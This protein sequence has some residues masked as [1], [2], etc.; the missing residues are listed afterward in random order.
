LPD[1][2]APHR[3]RAAKRAAETIRQGLAPLLARPQIGRK[4]EKAPSDLRRWMIGFSGSGYVI[5][6]QIKPNAIMI[7]S[8]RHGREMD[9]GPADPS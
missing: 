4:I 6:Y 7:A 3:P 2:I 5:V 8:T 9:T 1:F